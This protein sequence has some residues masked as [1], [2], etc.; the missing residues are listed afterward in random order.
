MTIGT[1]AYDTHFNYLQNQTVSYEDF[2]KVVGRA[3]GT[4][5]TPGRIEASYSLL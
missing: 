1:T 2:D 5:E 4:F 3:R